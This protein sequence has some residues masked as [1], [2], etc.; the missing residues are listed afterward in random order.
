MRPI[1]WRK[2]W[3]VILWL[4]PRWGSGH[5]I[6]IGHAEGC[7]VTGPQSSKA[8]KAQ[9]TNPES[10]PT[11]FDRLNWPSCPAVCFVG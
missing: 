2:D 6:H 4:P 9:S 7:K 11:L 5:P 10:V 3:T 8:G 1:F